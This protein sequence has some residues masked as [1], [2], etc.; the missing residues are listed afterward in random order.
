MD[1]PRKGRQTPTQ[2][3]ILPYADTLGNEAIDLYNQT[4]RKTQEWQ[5][6]LT[7]DIMVRTDTGLWLHTKFGYSVP[8]RNVKNEIVAIYEMWG[9]K[10]VKV[11]ST[12]RTCNDYSCT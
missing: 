10:N 9:L 5:E 12:G 6:I 3:V 7:Y 8:C 4:G 11:N 1:E 2:S